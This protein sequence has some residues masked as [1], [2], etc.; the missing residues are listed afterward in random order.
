MVL[1][2]A[3][4]CCGSRLALVLVFASLFIA[5]ED[6]ERAPAAKAPSS[7]SASAAPVDA[8]P[9]LDPVIEQGL[10][11]AER[12]RGE[13]AR[14]GE[15]GDLAA[16]QHHFAVYVQ[17]L[18]GELAA[19]DLD[20]VR[21]NLV[22]AA[23][24]AGCTERVSRKISEDLEAGFEAR[25]QK[26]LSDIDDIVGRGWTFLAVEVLPGAEVEENSGKSARYL[27][28]GCR[29]RFSAQATFAIALN[30]ARKPHALKLRPSFVMVDGQWRM[31]G[32]R[33]TAEGLDCEAET[34]EGICRTWQNQ[35]IR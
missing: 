2:E 21:S 20:A 22:S 12:A 17:G 31:V 9:A 30:N 7:A 8:P 16:A 35:V 25:Y 10:A 23:D 6:A 24:I 32:P 13:L 15:P 18:R 19:R 27:G 11:A 29:V 1:P 33:F 3:V 28:D 5:C 4:V 26:L 14:L 34:N